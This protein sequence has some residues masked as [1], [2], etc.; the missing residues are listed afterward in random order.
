M[1]KKIFFFIALIFVSINLFANIGP[2]ELVRKTA[3]DVISII[4][5]DKDIQAGDTNKIYKLAEEKIIP[6]FDFERISRLVLGKAWRTA[7][8]DQKTQ[9]KY[10]FKNL[11]LRTYAVALSKYKDQ[12]IEYKPLRMK[13]TDEIVTVKTEIIQSGAQPIDVDYALAKQDNGWLVI[14]IIIEGVSLVTNYRS[15]FASEIKRNGMDSLIKELA[16]KN[17]TNNN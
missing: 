7:T 17:K 9:F 8:D 4:K 10:E 13:P 15:Q 14:D 3:D 2:D 5:Q 6:N 1:F 12:K 16:N 11:L